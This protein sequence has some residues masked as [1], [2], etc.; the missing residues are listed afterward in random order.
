MHTISTRVVCAPDSTYTPKSYQTVSTVYFFDNKP[1][2]LG[3]PKTDLNLLP[4]ESEKPAKLWNEVTTFSSPE[5]V[6]S[7]SRAER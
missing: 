7:W 6:V 1:L 2:E 4:G 3:Y 5:P